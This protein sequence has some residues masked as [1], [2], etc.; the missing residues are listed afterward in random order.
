MTQIKCFSSLSPS[1]WIFCH[2]ANW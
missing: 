2:L 1:T